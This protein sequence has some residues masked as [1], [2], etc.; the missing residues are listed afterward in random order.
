M[1][2]PGRPA[3]AAAAAAA[4]SVMVVADRR[5]HRACSG[6]S[7]ATRIPA[8]PTDHDQL[9]VFKFKLEISCHCHGRTRRVVTS[10]DVIAY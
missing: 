8:G 7:P 9:P 1:T 6:P 2:P 10:S 3:A 4:A 5:A